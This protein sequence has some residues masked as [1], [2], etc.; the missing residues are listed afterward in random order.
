MTERTALEL[1]A[2]QLTELQESVSTASKFLRED[3][4]SEVCFWLSGTEGT[5]VRARMN[6]EQAWDDAGRPC[7]HERTTSH[8]YCT[9][10]GRDLC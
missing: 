7:N 2:E 5:A 1:L 4:L 3:N 10:C 6:A 8:L 9:D